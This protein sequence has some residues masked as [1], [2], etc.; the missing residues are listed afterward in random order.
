MLLIQTLLKPGNAPYYLPGTVL[1][2]RVR[3]FAYVSHTP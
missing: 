2:P 1:A 3:I